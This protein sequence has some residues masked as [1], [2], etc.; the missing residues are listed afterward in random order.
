MAK[1][2]HLDI[3][4]QDVYGWNKWRR[5]YPD[6]RP[7]L[8]GA[9]LQRAYLHQA[10]LSGADLSGADLSMAMLVEANLKETNLEETELFQANLALADL[11]G[12]DLRKARPFMADFG[13]ATLCR[14]DFRKVTLG[15]YQ[16]TVMV[17]WMSY[18][19]LSKSTLSIPLSRKQWN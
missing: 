11:S 19:T 10:N 14:V 9:N 18:S 7:D 1:Q 5:E 8:S 2:Q 17:T 6:I 4:K 13:E 3:L 12:T 16:S 15:C